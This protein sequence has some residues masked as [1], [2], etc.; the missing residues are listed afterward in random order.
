MTANPTT[1]EMIAERDTDVTT[2]RLIRATGAHRISGLR[3]R[4]WSPR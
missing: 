4:S 1:S 3:A 2:P